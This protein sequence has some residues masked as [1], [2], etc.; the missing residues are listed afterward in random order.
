MIVYGS[1]NFAW[2]EVA[3]LQSGMLQVVGEIAAVELLPTGV[4]AP[5]EDLVI[6]KIWFR[7]AECKRLRDFFTSRFQVLASHIMSREF[8][9]S[10]DWSVKIVPVEVVV[11]TNLLLASGDMMIVD[12]LSRFSRAAD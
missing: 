9:F 4:F 1:S 7:I 8:L 11:E 5:L 12:L 3:M 10:P 2:S 6:S